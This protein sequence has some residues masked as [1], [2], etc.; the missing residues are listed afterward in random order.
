MPEG[1][2]ATSDSADFPSTSPLVQVN[3]DVTEL[4]TAAPPIEAVSSFD[5]DKGV[6][7]IEPL[8]SGT[9]W[10]AGAPSAVWTGERFY[11]SYRLRRPQPERGGETR[12]AVSTDGEHFESI[13]SA[14][15]EDFNTASIERSAL[16]R[17]ADD[18]WRLYISYVDGADGR[19]RIDL[20]E[21]ARPDGFKPQ[22]RRRILTAADIGGEAV[23]DAWIGRN[24]AGWVMIASYVPTPD[25]TIDPQQLHGTK[26]IYNT[27]LSKSLSGLATSADGLAWHWEGPIFEP[28]ASGWD[29]YAA[30]LNTVVASATSW[31]AFYDGSASVDQNYEERCGIAVSDDLR[32]WQRLSKDGPAIGASGGPG[33][34]R[35]VEA[36]QAADWTRFYYE[37]T[38][39]DGAHELRTVRS[40]ARSG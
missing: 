37:Y 5:P 12:I 28:A 31:L 6:T 19:W 13:W 26:D 17:V 2:P 23:K 15:K 21:A 34:V 20:M 39:S 32:H 3:R 35:Y 27:G 36:V 24:G 11:L 30:R 33:T 18:H 8:G 29:A 25:E 10:W 14:Q 7:A 40:D 9:G 22:D 1:T 16:V 38:R 4:P